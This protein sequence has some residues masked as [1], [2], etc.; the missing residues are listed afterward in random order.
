MSKRKWSE[1]M[2]EL[3]VG[4]ENEVIQNPFSG[5]SATLDPV[6]VAVYDY[7]KG[8]ELTQIYTYFDDARYWFMKKNSKAYMTLLD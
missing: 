4:K 5:Q 8:C 3:Y 2:K 7:I 6:E 1:I